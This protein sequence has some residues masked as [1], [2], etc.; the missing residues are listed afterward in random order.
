MSQSTMSNTNKRK[1][2]REDMLA[3]VKK[4][5]AVEKPSAKLTEKSEQKEQPVEVVTRQLSLP[6]LWSELDVEV[7]MIKSRGK[8]ETICKLHEANDSRKRYVK[9]LM[10]A[11]MTHWTELGPDGNLG[12]TYSKTPD[13][14][15]QTVT[16]RGG[17]P[18]ELKGYYSDLESKQQPEF[19]QWLKQCITDMLTPCFY[20][21]SWKEITKDIELEEFIQGATVSCMKLMRDE[22]DEDIECVHATRGITD[23]N[24]MP[25]NVK[26]WK[27]NKEGTFD[28]IKKDFI[29]KGSMVQ[30]GGVLKAYRFLD[31]ENDEFKYGIKMEL[32]EDMVLISM[33]VKKKTTMASNIPFVE[34]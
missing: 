31:E 23:F 21:E 9:F 14:A 17:C 28:M 29:P 2:T 26:F 10:P 32:L 19:M 7:S 12:G 22:E 24:K 33:P 6:K 1:L 27:L 16:L 30:C 25:Q 8:D 34:Y 4:R 5:Q 11:L 3:R 20:D 13:K 15:K 18:I